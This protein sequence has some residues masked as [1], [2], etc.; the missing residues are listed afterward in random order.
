MIKLRNII[1]KY[2]ENK[3]SELVAI[4]DVDFN[5]EKG[6]FIAIVGVS[7]S[8]KTTLLNIMGL[9]DSNFYGTYTWDDIDM[10]KLSENEKS[11]FRN[12]KIGFVVQDFALVEHYT[13]RENITIPLDYKKGGITK[14][15]KEELIR[16]NLREFGLE[17]K[18]NVKAGN[19]SGGQRQRVAIIRAIIN[20][21]DLILA[22]EPTGALDGKN[23]EDVMNV[24]RRLNESGKTI[25]VITHDEKVA[26]FCH[27]KYSIIDGRLQGDVL[28]H[29]T[30]VVRL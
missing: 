2:N 11:R 14:K 26:D 21:P 5:V 6:D 16:S 8:G 24:L 3:P 15:E 9:M 12:E 25:I 27:K 22:D 28:A 19:L 10:T 18:I 4:N 7:G 13:V 23:T 1:K 17:D 20:N 29:N 30:E